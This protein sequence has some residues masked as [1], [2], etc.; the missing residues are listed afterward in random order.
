MSKSEAAVELSDPRVALVECRNYEQ[1]SIARALDEVQEMLG[2]WKGAL[3]DTGRVLLKPNMIA[4]KRPEKSVTTHPALIYETAKRL[5]EKGYEVFIGDSP[6]GAVRGLE[7]Y[8]KKT[9]IKEAA[10]RAGAELLNFESSGFERIV[11]NGRTY[12][13]AKPILDFD[14]ILNMPKLKTHVY[15]GL[16]GAVKNLFGSVPGLAKASMHQEAPKPGCFSKRLLDI[17]E[18]AAPSFHLADAVSVLD[19]RGPSSGRVRPMN[20]IMAAQDGVA[21]DALFA[22]LAGCSVKNYLTGSEARKRGY[23][24]VDLNNLKIVGKDPADLEPEDFKV[25]N[26]SIYRF[27]PGFMGRLSE[28]LIRAW[29]ESM[30][31]CT[32]CGFC[33]ESCP[34]DA[35]EV[36]SKRAIMDTKKCIL[37][38]CCHELCPE[39]A[40]DLQYSFLAR[41]LFH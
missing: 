33:A 31:N 36:V 9:E 7:R 38:L 2:L 5:K 12:S 34:V 1:K 13:I 37:C 41:R 3:P 11:R 21:M 30:S 20:C 4:A 22:H 16:T 6:G 29:P 26:I 40:V 35:I 17:Y 39:N 10:D 18:I 28:W 32:G 27:I 23:A 25:P 14:F 24:G 8:W 19:T 15:T